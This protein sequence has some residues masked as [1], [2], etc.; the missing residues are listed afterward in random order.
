M[1]IKSIPLIRLTSESEYNHTIASSNITFNKSS[2]LDNKSTEKN[3]VK[4][5][6]YSIS[7]DKG[8]IKNAYI[9]YNELNKENYPIINKSL[10]NKAKN[11]LL[12]NNLIEKDTVFYLNK[13]N[14]LYKDRSLNNKVEDNYN[15]MVEL[16]SFLKRTIYRLIYSRNIDL[17]NEVVKFIKEIDDYLY[18][19]PYIKDIISYIRFNIN[20]K[21]S[22]FTNTDN[23]ILKTNDF[24]KFN[25]VNTKSINMDDMYCFTTNA[26][27]Y[28]PEAEGSLSN[29][30]PNDKKILNNINEIDY[31]KD[32]TLNILEKIKNNSNILFINRDTISNIGKLNNPNNRIIYEIKK[33]NKEALCN[34]DKGF[35]ENYIEFT[36]DN[37]DK[38]DSK[39]VDVLEVVHKI[40]NY[41]E[42][43][44][45]SR[46]KNKKSIL[47]KNLEL[48]KYLGLIMENESSTTLYS[49]GLPKVYNLGDFIDITSIII[50]K[51]NHIGHLKELDMYLKK[52]MGYISILITYNGDGGSLRPDDPTE[53]PKPDK[54]NI[55]IVNGGFND[56]SLIINPNTYFK[57]KLGLPDGVTISSVSNVPDGI[58]FDKYTNTMEG[59]YMSTKPHDINLIIGESAT[60]ITIKA[61]DIVQYLI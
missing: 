27:I 8:K 17:N 19:T 15:T 49:K 61:S 43:K 28:G 31:T 4:D 36:L 12:N 59:Y 40:K 60:K 26:I 23:V 56:I 45:I 39:I 47:F 32:L 2:K 48:I 13:D 10:Y 50:H 9:I 7:K 35:R 3:K 11:H 38:K 41:I 52:I 25:K 54:P 21:K 24:I 44:F 55:V 46:K 20:D 18:I 51:L 30:T 58:I 33:Q 57:I 53:E 29:F 16:N 6:I 22:N 34:T 14:S 1:A 42:T 37:N 5:L